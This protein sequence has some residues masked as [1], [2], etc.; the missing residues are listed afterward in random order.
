MEVPR[1]GGQIRAV[2]SATPDPSHICN[3][4]CNK[5]RDRT[6]ILMHTSWVLNQLSHNGNSQ[7]NFSRQE[8]K[9]RTCEKDKN[10]C[11]KSENY[12]WE[13]I[14]GKGNKHIVTF[15]A[16]PRLDLATSFQFNLYWV[17]WRLWVCGNISRAYEWGLF[18]QWAQWAL[19]DLQ[20]SIAIWIA[21]WETL[22]YC[23]ICKHYGSEFRRRV[24]LDIFMDVTI[25]PAPNGGVAESPAL[26][27]GKR[28]KGR[29]P[30]AS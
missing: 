17:Q 7:L 28:G 12:Y 23:L 14:W 29:P 4:C 22:A 13:G 9:E 2:A 21:K 26:N 15:S 16:L 20:G 3:L 11:G 8:C 25:C 5:V 19:G 18:S 6:C 27:L 1:L 10:K 24:I 30:L